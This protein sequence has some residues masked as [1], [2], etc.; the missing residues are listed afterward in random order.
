MGVAKK[1]CSGGKG[2]GP[3]ALRGGG[4]QIPVLDFALSAVF[5]LA[6]VERNRIPD[7]PGRQD[8]GVWRHGIHIGKAKTVL[9]GVPM[10]L[11][12]C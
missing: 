2:V 3:V 5:D 6:L 1:G 9:D 4:Q 7:R 8:T 12:A 11:T 10:I